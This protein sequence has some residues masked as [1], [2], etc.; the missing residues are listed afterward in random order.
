MA[1]YWCDPYLEATNQGN[2]TTDTTTRSGTYAA[3]FSISDLC[4]DI[5][6]TG[7]PSTMV[8]G[9]GST[10]FASGDEIRF[11]GLPVDT[12][13]NNSLG[14]IYWQQRYRIAPYQQ[15]SSTGDWYTNKT[16]TEG[17]FCFKAAT[18]K[19]ANN[20]RW[21]TNTSTDS[22]DVPLMFS[23]D[24]LGTGS[25]LD[26]DN[27]EGFGG[28]YRSVY[29]NNGPDSAN[30]KSNPVLYQMNPDYYHQTNPC[31]GT[32][33][34]HHFFPIDNVTMTAGWDSE[35]TQDGY[36]LIQANPNGSG[37]SDYGAAGTSTKYMVLF[38]NTSGSD[39][40]GLDRMFFV[41][42][43][44]YYVYLGYQTDVPN[45]TLGG[46][47][48]DN[49]YAYFGTYYNT[50]TSDVTHK[51]N[52][53]AS[54][55]PSLN[56][57]P[58]QSS[59][60]KYTIEWDFL[61]SYYISL[62]NNLQQYGTFTSGETKH[63]GDI[64]VGSTY[65]YNPQSLD[66]YFYNY[67]GNSSSRQNGTIT[68][69]SG[70]MFGS[71]YVSNNANYGQGLLFGSTTYG[72]QLPR[73][74]GYVYE[75]TLHIIGTV[76]GP[77]EYYENAA[78]ISF[79]PRYGSNQSNDYAFGVNNFKLTGNKW[80]TAYINTSNIQSP[81][82]QRIY[83]LGV[84]QCN[85]QN[86]QTTNC[87]IPYGS[88]A[89]FSSYSGRVVPTLFCFDSNDYDGKAL[90]SVSNAGSSGSNVSGFAWN[91]TIG[92]VDCLVV[93]PPTNVTS[94]YDFNLPMVLSVPTYTPS[95]DNLRIKVVGWIHDANQEGQLV[96]SVGFRDSSVVNANYN[97]G[98]GSSGT[99]SGSRWQSVYSSESPM[100]SISSSSPDTLY[101]NL[102][103][104]NASETHPITT[105]NT[106]LRFRS[107]NQSETRR[108]ITNVEV[109]TY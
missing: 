52:F 5:S 56:F 86:Y 66:H 9:V 98:G 10:T 87:D 68:F 15:N 26:F 19:E 42:R 71:S 22:G 54:R 11:K 88:I 90:I 37:T 48:Q 23:A 51:I 36:S 28:V 47:L 65:I 39:L 82:P 31:S 8:T 80:Y 83:S 21:H 84:L 91:D 100:T 2:G 107:Y 109:E 7:N 57:S 79:G 49:P 89:D 62:N 97:Y 85:N 99:Y 76:G 77:A 14:Q 59:T 63:N 78:H 45:I 17:T 55:N 103:S 72:T 105:L 32:N 81:Q 44:Y 69:K 73:V 25:T 24:N 43:R 61:S 30:T 4:I 3:P 70:A 67:Y 12:L 6:T 13:F 95:T 75:D 108:Y 64:K 92:G 46:I 50:H 96:A 94:G 16:T 93:R 1:V 27:L 40:T 41:G 58:N 38:A 104:V 102:T 34:A 18:L 29:T 74:G 35:T 106:I 60:H 101:F 33:Y 20:A 53:L